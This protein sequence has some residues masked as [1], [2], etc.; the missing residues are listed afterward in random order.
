VERQVA[1]SVDGGDIGESL[2]ENGIQKG[3][4]AAFGDGVREG[5]RLSGRARSERSSGSGSESLISGG[6][7]GRFERRSGVGGGGRSDGRRRWQGYIIDGI[8]RENLRG[9][10][11]HMSVATFRR[12][13]FLGS[14]V[15]ATIFPCCPT[16]S[17]I[18]SRWPTERRRA[19]RHLHRPRS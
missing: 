4:G 10:I 9:D 7:E 5:Q 12:R 13:H 19:R 15:R 17:G 6:F 3:G 14:P 16:Y 2:G 18:D 11:S 1:N 8:R